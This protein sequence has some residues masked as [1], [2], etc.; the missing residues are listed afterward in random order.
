MEQN[1]RE[2]RMARVLAKG[3]A[4]AESLVM[5]KSVFLFSSK[6]PTCV[7]TEQNSQ[8]ILSLAFGR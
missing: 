4:I 6:G 5:A 2:G 7:L 1:Q 8:N 3:K